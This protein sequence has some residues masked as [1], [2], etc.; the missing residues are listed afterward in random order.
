MH[1]WA[2]RIEPRGR[3]APEHLADLLGIALDGTAPGR[4]SAPV[5]SHLTLLL[6][7]R[8]NVALPSAEADEMS[9]ESSADL[10]PE[11][12]EPDEAGASP[13][14]AEAPSAPA[15]ILAPHDIATLAIPPEDV[16]PTLARLEARTDAHRFIFGQSVRYFCAAAR[17]VASMLVGQR[18]VPAVALESSGDLRGSW[19]LWLQTDESRHRLSLL[20]RAMP[21]VVR[22]A[23]DEF[24][25]DGAAMLTDFLSAVAD[26][27]VRRALL[28][29]D[30][31]SAVEMW[32]RGPDEHV[33]WLAALLGAEHRISAGTGLTV[34][35]TRGA[36]EWV[37]RLRD[38]SPQQQYRLHL[39][40]AEPAAPAGGPWPD[41]FNPEAHGD[42]PWTISFYLQAFDDPNH[43][44]E[45]SRIWKSPGDVHFFEGRRIEHPQELLLKE[46]KRASR[47][48]SL[49]DTVLAGAT[50]SVI[51]LTTRQAYLFMRDVR[52]LLQ[53]SG[54]SVDIPS[55][56]DN[57]ERGISLRLKVDSEELPSEGVRS[58]GFSPA[59]RATLGL[60]SLVDFSWQIALGDQA[61]TF[62]EF[63]RLAR[64]RGPLIRWK[65]RWIELRAEDLAAAEDF[66]RKQ[67]RGQIT[68]REA[69]QMAY[70]P[71]AGRLG[72]PVSGLD[73]TGWVSYLLTPQTSGTR[74]P[75]VPQ[76]AQF[77]GT[78]RPYQVK[79]LSWLAFLDQYGLGACLADDMGLGKTIQFISLL[80]AERQAPDG[81]T[82]APVIGPTLLVVPTSVIANWVRE[83]HR[84]SPNLRVR[85]H[86]GPM[87]E[88][89]PRLIENA[90]SADIIITTY[91][92]A[93]RDREW[94]SQVNWWRVCLDEAQNIK[95]PTAKQ[96][97]AIRAIQAPR[98]IALTGTPVENRLSELWSIMEFCNPG[99][100]GTPG[101]FRREYAV[102]VERLRDR[103]RAAQLRGMVQP[104]VLRRLKTDPSVI[105]DLPEKLETKVYCPLTSEQARLY[106]AVV[107]QLIETADQAEGIRRRGLVL[108]SLIK[109]KQICNH[110]AHYWG[111]G[112]D[113]QGGTGTDLTGRSG[114]TRRLL[115]MLDEVI[116]EGDSALIFTQFREMGHLLT[117]LIRA[118][119][120]IDA[121]FMHGGTPP[122]KRQ[123]LID[124]FQKRDGTCPLFV[125]SL[126][127]G[128][129][130]LNLTAANHVFHFDRWWNPAVE[131]QAT[132]RAFRIGQHRAVQVHK[133]ICAG[134]LEERIDEMIEQKTE[135]AQKIIGSGEAWLTELST[136][137]LHEILKLR[138]D[139]VETDDD[140]SI[141]ESA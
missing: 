42:L 84:F 126:K 26:A 46:L 121:L 7:T 91:A 1:L 53:E 79:G 105:A 49:L 89:G 9:A 131:N 39:H 72:L 114:K 33:A 4:L 108:A 97:V 38:P 62:E 71:A 94:M 69:L 118:E 130:G 40:L 11:G 113:P 60:D 77:L 20:I 41:L 99:Y 58:M 100:L 138:Y 78:L 51:E 37:G 137:Q 24:R 17:L 50:P 103:S 110:P 134:T 95:N 88:S 107:N 106:E 92:L 23:T 56:W 129:V 67:I 127:V 81:A 102:P 123:Q 133:F 66:L 52:P 15:P 8:D 22:A 75:M 101:E 57:P 68:V 85:V 64:E 111:Q 54:F 124:R 119:L 59:G 27:A 6:P 65:N 25:H 116:A 29:H 47:V 140:T 96:A 63:R 70:G 93:Y 122:G 21:P 30:M 12:E 3:L 55:W 36:R 128:G 132:D 98:R 120:N 32:D 87:R 43:L 135:L 74:M 31:K 44:V 139:A 83:F 18:L 5:P 141:R 76:P 117:R 61:L 13:A 34:E 45:A 80:L 19:R 112:E 125:L 10:G 28:Q 73:A 14:A 35:L 86:H 2:E 16:L 115:E 109:L 48:F 104:F 136:S 82:E 90:A